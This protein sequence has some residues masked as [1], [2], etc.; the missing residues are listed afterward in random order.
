MQRRLCSTTY[1]RVLYVYINSG[2][3]LC[4][5]TPSPNNIVIA[6]IV[7]T[8]LSHHDDRIWHTKNESNTKHHHHH[9]CRPSQHEFCWS[10][11]RVRIYQQRIW[12]VHRI[13]TCVSPFCQTKSIGSKL[14]SNAAHWI[15]VG[16]KHSTSKVSQ[17]KNWIHVCSICMFSTMIDFPE[18]IRS[19]KC[20][21]HCVK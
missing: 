15:R 16:M 5:T 14:K 1:K 12:A 7:A 17:S 4:R 11:A 13:R 3:I 10:I 8:A 18:T 21:C 20:F 9:H 6:I 19:E 2:L